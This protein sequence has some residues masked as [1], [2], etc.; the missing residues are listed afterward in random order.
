MTT[1]LLN[2]NW[3]HTLVALYVAVPKAV[4][5]GYTTDNQLV[6]Q[7]VATYFFV[8]RPEYTDKIGVYNADGTETA[9][10]DQSTIAAIYDTLTGFRARVIT[11]ANAMAR[12]DVIGETP[13]AFKVRFVI[14]DEPYNMCEPEPE[15]YKYVLYTPAK[16]FGEKAR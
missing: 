1:Q 7:A 5:E 15:G 4:F 6:W 3:K 13:D 14:H 2:K 9:V 8:H 10:T 12:R 16:L 11:Y